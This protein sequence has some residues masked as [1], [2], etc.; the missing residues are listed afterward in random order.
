[1]TALDDR[2]LPVFARQHW[3]VRLSDVRAAGGSAAC[4]SN[5]VRAGTWSQ[6]DVSVYQLTGAPASWE[7]RV[8]APLLAIGGPALASHLTAAALHSVPGFGRGTPEISVHTSTDLDRCERVVVD[9]VPVT[10]VARTLLDI[11]RLVGD[12]RL[13]RAIEWARRE[14]KVDW[15]TLI[16]TLARHARRGRPGIRR[17]RRVIVAN[18]E[19]DEITDSDFELLVLALIAEAGL[20]TPVLH[21]RVLDGERFVA[22]VDL[23]YP[24]LQIAIE[25]DGRVHLDADV[26]E[27]DVARQNDLVLAGWTV[28]RFSYE[29]Y[30]RRPEQVVA[31][32]RAAISA[33]RLAA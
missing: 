9:G 22:E 28:L 10:D 4:A 2:L 5:R 30:R 6:A 16:S 11:G 23:A 32:I 21:H 20:P 31:E 17:L 12:R 24:A 27:R 29:R 15:P 8:L 13:L 18:V 7:G 1:M 33:A 3:L 25:L 26:H 14:G 19:R